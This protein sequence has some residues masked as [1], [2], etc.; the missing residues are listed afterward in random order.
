MEIRVPHGLSPN[1][2]HERMR[3]LAQENAVE[4][5]THDDGSGG[6]LRK[7]TP[8]GAVSASFAVEPSEIIVRI[9]QKPAFLPERKVREM[10]EEGLRDALA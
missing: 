1:E 6:S 9:D 7:G 8:L 2:V 4:L 5:E 10:L 3:K